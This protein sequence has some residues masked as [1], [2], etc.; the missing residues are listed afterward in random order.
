MICKS[1]KSLVAKCT[2][3]KGIEKAKLWTEDKQR[4]KGPKDRLG[5]CDGIGNGPD[6]RSGFYR[7]PGSGPLKIRDTWARPVLFRERI[8]VFRGRGFSE[9]GNRAPGPD[10]FA[11]HR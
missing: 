2:Y 3:E 11:D 10:L 4:Q 8:G 9:P 1:I 5:V 6:P 7:S